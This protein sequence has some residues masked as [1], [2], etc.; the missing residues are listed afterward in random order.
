M[1]VAIITRDQNRSPKILAIGLQDMLKKI[2]IESKI[3]FESTGYLQRISS[4]FRR[5]RYPISFHYRL[6]RKLKHLTID[7][8]ITKE[9][10]QFD[11]IVVSE[12]TPNAFWKGYMDI[13]KLREK[14]GKPIALYEVY[15]LGNSETHT[16]GLKENGDYGIERYDWHFSVS[17]TTEVKSSP[18]NAIKWSVIG[19]NLD[20]FKIEVKRRSGFMTCFDFPQFGYEKIRSEQMEVVADLGINKVILE[21]EYEMEEIREV[22]SMS[23]VLFVQFPEAFGLPIAECL[24]SGCKIYVPN[25]YWAM[26]WR[27][28][29]ENGNWF[30]PEECFTIYKDA[31]D[32]KSKLSYFYSSYD[33]DN[34]PKLI[35][36]AFL[37]YYPDFYIGDAK[38]LEVGLSNLVG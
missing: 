6:R 3:F 38:S 16:K 23:S 19:L 29:D 30:L 27:L 5:T 21:G 4:V 37:K 31:Q 25:I 32:L 14:T 28:Q 35:R 7:W 13:E 15:Y 20:V 8:Q 36:D 18:L 24:A 9:L 22:Y 2:G 11:I 1:R 10:R 12:C 26:S 17:D 33:V 34:T